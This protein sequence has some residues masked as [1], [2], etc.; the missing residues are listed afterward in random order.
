MH[1]SPFEVTVICV[2]HSSQQLDAIPNQFDFCMNLLE[3]PDLLSTSPA[4][5][6]HKLFVLHDFSEA[7]LQ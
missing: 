2:A 1:V 4:K 7:R 6:F 5:V 3:N